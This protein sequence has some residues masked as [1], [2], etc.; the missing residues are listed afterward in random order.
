MSGDGGQH[1]LGEGWSRLF[2]WLKRVCWGELKFQGRVVINWLSSALRWSWL[3]N[4]PL[5]SQ[6]ES[7]WEGA[8]PWQGQKE[9]S[10]TKSPLL[11]SDSLWFADT[12]D[13]SLPTDISLSWLKGWRSFWIPFFSRYYQWMGSP[14]NHCS[15][16][17]LI[18]LY[19]SAVDLQSCVSF[20]C[21]AK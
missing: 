3:F 2:F 6:W 1:L 21:R 14:E 20:K 17:F 19:W 5:L 4:S 11:E 8:V 16:V 13:S 7:E 15:F 9:S 12:L 10:G 18:K